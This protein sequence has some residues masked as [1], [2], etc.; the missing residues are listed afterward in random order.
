MIGD[1]MNLIGCFL[2][3]QLPTMTGLALLYCILQ[4]IMFTQY[5]Y[6]RYVKHSVVNHPGDE[7]I[8]KALLFSPPRMP[9]LRSP[10]YKYVKANRNEDDVIA[11]NEH[12]GSSSHTF[13]PSTLKRKASLPYNKNSATYLAV[14][15]PCI[16]YSISNIFAEERSI[17]HTN[18]RGSNRVLL[19][20]GKKRKYGT[21][22]TYF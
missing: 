15:V 16:I 14:I 7:K 5:L 13:S 8:P 6:F 19:S 17:L 11:S 3:T 2:S 18:V 21:K 1:I 22:N 10:V 12:F 9:Y 20:L 4:S